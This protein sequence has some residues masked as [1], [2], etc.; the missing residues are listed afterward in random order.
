MPFLSSWKPFSIHPSCF[1][2]FSLGL[3]SMNWSIIFIRKWNLF[4][5]YWKLNCFGTWGSI[6]SSSPMVWRW[7][8][9]IS[10]L[11]ST[12]IPKLEIETLWI[13]FFS[14]LFTEMGTKSVSKLKQISILIALTSICNPFIIQLLSFIQ[15]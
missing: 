11:F 7:T 8:D 1:C 2:K 10:C 3:S 13:N 4:T 5:T 6:F 15:L 9:Y 12:P 14:S